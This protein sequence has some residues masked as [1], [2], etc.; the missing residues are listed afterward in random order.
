MRESIAERAPSAIVFQALVR[1]GRVRETLFVND[2]RLAIVRA[3]LDVAIASGKTITVKVTMAS[4]DTRTVSGI[5]MSWH[6]GRDGR[7]RIGLL[8]GTQ[9]QQALLLE[10]I[11]EVIAADA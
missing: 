11:A 1:D 6:T 10:S 2:D 9:T 7:E 8:I 3:A 5:A 4:G